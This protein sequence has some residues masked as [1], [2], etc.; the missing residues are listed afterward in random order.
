[1]ERRFGPYSFDLVDELR[2]ERDESGQIIEYAYALGSVRL[3]PHSKGPFCNFNLG[4]AGS[5][6]GVYVIQVQD[7][8]VYVGEC[9]NLRTRFGSTGYGH[10][11]ARNCHHDGQATNCKINGRVLQAAKTGRTIRVWFCESD[12]RHEV[13]HALIHELQPEWNSQRPTGLVRQRN[14]NSPTATAQCAPNDFRAALDRELGA[15]GARKLTAVRIKAGDLHRSVGGY[16]GPNHR[17][18]ICCAAMRAAMQSGDRVVDGPPS[19]KGASLTIEYRLPR[20][21]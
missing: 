10:V 4:R 7:Q 17:M 5:A 3:N 20:G 21:Q 8:V 19:G 11:A 14:T 16:P 1:M 9:E 15:A 18:P 2:P 6:A 13:E 12:Q